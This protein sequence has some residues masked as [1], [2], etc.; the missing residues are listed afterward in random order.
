MGN[1]EEHCCVACEDVFSTGPPVKPVLLAEEFRPCCVLQ[2]QF[3]IDLFCL[4]VYF[5][6][7]HLKFT[8]SNKPVFFL[9]NGTQGDDVKYPCVPKGGDIGFPNTVI[10]LDPS[11][12]LL[13]RCPRPALSL[14]PFSPH[15]ASKSY[16]IYRIACARARLAQG[17][18]RKGVDAINFERFW[19]DCLIQF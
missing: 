6:V 1:T 2:N 19:F 4:C 18:S 16:N 3:C 14:L 7:Y 5:H 13:T 12:A 11:A 15:L 8:Q 10:Q 17:K 9:N